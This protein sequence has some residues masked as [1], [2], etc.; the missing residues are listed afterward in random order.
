MAAG[1][2][3]R[4]DPRLRAASEAGEIEIK[5]YPSVGAGARVKVPS[6]WMSRFSTTT[7]VALPSGPSVKAMPAVP[8]ADSPW[9]T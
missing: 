4:A 1:G 6:P 2:A 9:V 5:R 3:E 8:A 7:L